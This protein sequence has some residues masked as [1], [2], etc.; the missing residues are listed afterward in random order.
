LLFSR[1]A[2]QADAKGY[3]LVELLVAM[4]ITLSVLAS[5]LTIAS[6]LQLGFGT[7]GE[8]ADGQQRLRVAMNAISR[9]LSRAG[10]G[11]FQ[12]ANGGPLGFSVAAVFP[13]RQGAVRPDLPGTIRSDVMTVA[14]VPAQTAAQTTI[15]QPM[16]ATSGTAFI[17]LDP[18]C[19]PV[20]PACGF[21]AGMD[22]MLYDDTGSYDTFRVL[23]AQPGSLELQHTMT[24][25][26]QAYAADARIVEASSHTYYLKA[27]PATDTVQLMHYDGVAS[28]VAVVDHVVGLAFEYFG[29]PAPPRLVRPVADPTGPWTTY[30]PKPPRPGV[31]S[32]AYPPGENCVFQLDPTGTQQVPRLG[33]LGVGMTLVKLAVA[34]LSDGPWCPD[35]VNAHRYDADLLRIRRVSVTLRLEAALSA[36]RGPAGSLF[37]RGGTARAAGRWLPDQEI[38]FDVTPRNLNIGR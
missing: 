30:G 16:T 8:R 22:V 3:S 38:R 33:T 29:E 23:T 27:D 21:S 31:Q 28:D 20:D 34:Q 2:S 25:T 6:G 1:H 11:S 4:G 36:L 10:T 37:T 14:Y 19:P 9:D 18:G 5:T 32:T 7:E 35:A 24:N 26:A 17:N 15:R 13:F 12:G